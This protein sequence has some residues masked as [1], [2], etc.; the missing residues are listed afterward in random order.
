MPSPSADREQRLFTQVRDTEQGRIEK[1]AG[2][3]GKEKQID[4]EIGT[5]RQRREGYRGRD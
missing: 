1:E 5:E 3:T 4:T 2:R